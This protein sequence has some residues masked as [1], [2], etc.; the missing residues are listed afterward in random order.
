MADECHARAN[1][2]G[3]AENVIGMNMRIDDVANRLCCHGADRGEETGALARA[4]A[5]VDH[6]DGIVAYDE[7]DVGDVAFVGLG[8]QI[9]G[10]GVNVD[11]GRNLRRRQRREC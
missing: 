9:D 3:V 11:P 7:A 4:A 2:G 10:A 6:R 5:G 8:H 1:E